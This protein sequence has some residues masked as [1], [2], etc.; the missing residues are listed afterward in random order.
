MQG[1]STVAA[2]IRLISSAIGSLPLILYAKNG[3]SKTQLFNDSVYSLLRYQPNPESTIQTLLTSLVQDVL[4]RGNGYLELVRTGNRIS[5]L[6]YI[7]AEHVRVYRDTKTGDLQY[8][9][10]I[11]TNRRT[12]PPSS[13]VHV[14]GQPS[15]DGVTGLSCL[16]TSRDIIAES[17]ALQRH[18]NLYFK[19]VSQPTGILSTTD[20]LKPEDR[21]M[22]RDNWHKL[23]GG[24]SKFTTAV[25]DSSLSYTPLDTTNNVDSDLVKAREYSRQAVSSLFGC[26]PSLICSE[27]RTSG[28]TQTSLTIGLLEFGLKPIM[29]KIETELLRKLFPNQMSQ[30][31]IE[32]NFMDLLKSDPVTFMQSLSVVRAAGVYKTSELRELCGLNGLEGDE[33]ELDN[34]ILA[35]VNLCDS[36]V[37]IGKPVDPKI[38]PMGSGEGNN[39]Q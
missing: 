28:E 14:T 15:S 1:S 13:I 7:S 16:Q 30:Y 17:I 37:L 23:T 34:M 24:G 11:G 31:A 2:C 35:P 39:E 33:A 5:G 21:S 9:I 20:K 25:L 32:F 19:N 26:P 6:W 3:N 38:A 27:Q 8:E 29:R 18:A 22:I 12:L 10:T 36:R 4:L